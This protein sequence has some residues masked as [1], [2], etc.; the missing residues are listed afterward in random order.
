MSESPPW[1]D[2]RRT[3]EA[4][5]PMGDASKKYG[6]KYETLK[7]RAQRERWITDNAIKRALAV[8]QQAKENAP[9]MSLKPT[10]ESIIAASLEENG[11]KV[12]RAALAIARA[13]LERVS[14]AGTLA[15][16]NWADFKTATEIGL[17]AAGLDSNN[18]P[19]VQIL[20][21]DAPARILDA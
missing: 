2:I 15:I 8:R 20:I 6:V 16:E 21:T 18:A 17:K 11:D 19:P 7:K 4:G 10:P 13:E 9:A 5:V 3:V 14:R 12:R 1:E